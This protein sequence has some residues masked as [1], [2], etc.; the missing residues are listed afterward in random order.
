MPALIEK[1]RQERLSIAGE[2]AKL[3]QEVQAFLFGC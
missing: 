1:F 3:S 2:V